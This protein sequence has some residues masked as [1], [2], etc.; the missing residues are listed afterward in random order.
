MNALQKAAMTAGAF[1]TGGV[2][3]YYGVKAI[4]DSGTT[5]IKDLLKNRLLSTKGE[6]NKDQWTARLTSLRKD[7]IKKE[8]LTLELQEIKDSS[9]NKTWESLRDLC[10]SRIEKE[11]SKEDSI[12]REVVDYCTFR[13]KDKLGNKVI[14]E[15][16]ETGGNLKN[17]GQWKKVSD[18]LKDKVG[19][20]S[21]IITE[22]QTKLKANQSPDAHALRKWCE[23]AY[24]TPWINNEESNFQD[25]Q[26]H[27]LSSDN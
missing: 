6:Q 1:G 15:A 21:P 12:F 8:S 11:Y 4:K 19:T 23:E 17:N 7:S 14:V 2:G 22:I 26:Q 27:C 24:E 18:A 3:S 25:A 9:K 20:F 16:T 5:K 13:N 10:A